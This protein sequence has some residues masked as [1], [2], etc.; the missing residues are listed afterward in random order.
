M[1]VSGKLD[2]HV[3]IYS[4]DKIQSAIAAGDWETD[5]F[6]VPILEFDDVVEAQVEVGLG[7]L[8]SQFDNQGYAYTSLF[9][10]PAVARWSLGGDYAELNDDPEWSLV[11][12]INVHYN[13]G[14]IA[15]AEGDTV[16]PDGRY[17]VSLN[18]W[19]IDRFLTVGPLVPQNLQLIDISQK[20]NLPKQS[21]E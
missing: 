18:K 19:A 17:L 3:T 5:E 14:H 13:V 15:A 10:E 7:P 12:K 11:S 1:V 20:E 2:P 4:F 6:G 9:L 21:Y 8:H 16:S